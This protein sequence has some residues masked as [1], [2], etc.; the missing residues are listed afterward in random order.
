MAR[1]LFLAA[2]VFYAGCN[3]G[4]PEEDSLDQARLLYRAG[5]YS[6]ALMLYQEIADSGE[7]DPLIQLEYAETA[8]LASQTERSRTYRQMALEA[9]TALDADRGEV[10][11]AVIGELWR[12]LGW[13]MVRDR[14][15][16]QAY[17][18]FERALQIEGMD[19]VFEDEWLLRGTYSGSHLSQVASL[20]DSLFGTP[21]ADS[22]LSITAEK[23]LVELDRISLVRTDLR[24]A[25]LRARAMLLPYVDRPLEEL[26]V[27]TELDRLGGIDPGWRHRRMELLL[28]IAADDI[29]QGRASLA[30]EK[31]L[32]VWSSDF[33]G[34]QVKAAVMLGGM[35]EQA[36]DASQAL[37]WYRDACQVSPSLTSPAALTAAAKR[38]SLL[39]LLP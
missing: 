9:L 16:L 1:V 15:S 13:E 33:A 14:D 38:D 23:H 26:E 31:L 30:R 39:Y 35:A 21:E 28:Q 32:E 22:I 25:V 10:D 17:S 11:P 4:G 20:P 36:G 7:Y 12:R 24:R 18:V 34:E 37:Q 3:S 8:V 6:Q 2:I 27:L 29:E 5:R 19:Q